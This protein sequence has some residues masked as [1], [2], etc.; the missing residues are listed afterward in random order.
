[1]RI[2]VRPAALK[3]YLSTFAKGSGHATGFCEKPGKLQN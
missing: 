1:M 2:T 3:V